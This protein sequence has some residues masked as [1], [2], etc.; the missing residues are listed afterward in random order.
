MQ[1]LGVCGCHLDRGPALAGQ[2]AAAAW[3][4]AGGGHCVWQG[5]FRAG[6]GGFVRRKGPPD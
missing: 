5:A 4:Q 3:R 2:P 1:D 6:H